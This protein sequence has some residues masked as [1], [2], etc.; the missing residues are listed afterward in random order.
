MAVDLLKQSAAKMKSVKALVSHYPTCTIV[1]KL[2]NIGSRSGQMHINCGYSE[3]EEPFVKTLDNALQSFGVQ[4]QQYFGGGIYWQTCTQGIEGQVLHVHMNNLYCFRY[5]TS[6]LYAH[7][8]LSWHKRN[9][10]TYLE[11]YLVK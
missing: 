1:F 3:K 9:C 7:L 4:R 6:R 2:V 11:R 10:P 5:Q 8:Y